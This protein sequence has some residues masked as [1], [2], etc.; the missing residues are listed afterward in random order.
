MKQAP[1]IVVIYDGINNSVFD[2]QVMQPLKN[3]LEVQPQ[4][5]IILISFEKT[6]PTQKLIA[7]K[8]F[9][10]P[11]FA[12]IV[13]KKIPYIG[14]LSLYYAAMN[15]KKKITKYPC[16]TM[17]ARGPLAGFIA[18]KVCRSIACI[19]LTIQAR[20]LLA[21]EYAYENETNNSSILDILW[22]GLRTRQFFNIEYTTYTKNILSSSFPITIQSVSSSLAEYLV[23]VY[24]ADRRKITIAKHDIPH[25]IN[26]VQLT[27]WKIQTRT[28][29]NI[30]MQATVYCY[31]GSIKPWQCPEQVITRFVTHRTQNPHAFLL[32]LT[33][34]T[35]AFKILIQK[36]HIPIDAY[37]I[38]H[39]AHSDIYRYLAG[40]DIG[41]LFRDPHIVN[42]VSRPT[43]ALEYAAVNLTIE[44]NNTVSWLF[45]RTIGTPIHSLVSAEKFFELKDQSVLIVK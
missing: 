10:H 43:K 2:S 5:R 41:M 27:N 19:S 44:H 29:L 33:Q 32:I 21:Q 35:D 8:I 12:F 34:D 3:I 24:H 17:I 26:P 28:E 15:L 40:A 14:K 22:H 18:Q 36:Y 37:R 20:G 31:N 9:N 6:H 25:K 23:T 4:Q 13:C 39:V 11:S 45:E 42:W 16:Y 7:Q 1:L 30:P 38:L